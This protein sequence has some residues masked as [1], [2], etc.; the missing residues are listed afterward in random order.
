MEKVKVTQ[1]QAESIER[2][3]EEITKRHEQLKDNPMYVDEWAKPLL[4]MSTNDYVNA[5][6]VGYEV[7]PD[8]K[9]GDY[10]VVHGYAKE[11]NG[12]VLEITNI[13]K[14]REDFIY[15]EPSENHNDNFS[16]QGCDVRH[17]TP[18]EIDKE[19]ERIFFEENDRLPWEL[20]INDVLI[21]RHTER[22]AV[23]THAEEGCVK[24]DIHSKIMNIDDL[25]LNNKVLCFAE[26]RKDLEGDK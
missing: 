4:K 11:Y 22:P 5:I 2:H 15:F 20:K 10:V 13:I 14:E 9:I 25:K 19:K 12:K 23:V 8:Y 1:E 24:L 3:K 26:D 17:A 16:L 6:H 18:A 21:N 7:V